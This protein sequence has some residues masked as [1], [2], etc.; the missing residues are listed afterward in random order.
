MQCLAFKEAWL[1]VL[2]V[3]DKQLKYLE[4]TVLNVM[5]TPAP[6]S[7]YADIKVWNA[8]SLELYVALFVLSYTFNLTRSIALGVEMCYSSLTVCVFDVPTNM[9]WTKQLPLTTRLNSSIPCPVVNQCEQVI[10]YSA[11]I[12]H[13]PVWFLSWDSS[14]VTISQRTICLLAHS[15]IKVYKTKNKKIQHG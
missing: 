5:K 10:T 11:P 9:T 6:D 13:S 2:D 14:V 1:I 7:I 12:T 4:K 8:V 15:L 3:A